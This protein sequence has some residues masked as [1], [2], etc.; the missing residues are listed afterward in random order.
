M[1]AASMLRSEWR[2]CSPASGEIRV[3]GV[4][5]DALSRHHWLKQVA[6]VEQHPSL[7][8]GSL[9]ETLRALAPEASD[10]ELVEALLQVGLG[11]WLA[12]LPRG[13]ATEL[14]D[15]GG[16]VSGGQRAR[17]ALARALLKKPRLV[18]LDEPT[19]ALDAEA[20]RAFDARL[21]ELLGNTTRL[22]ISHQGSHFSNLDAR[23]RLQDGRLIAREATA[24]P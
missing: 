10:A 11:D 12:A 19:A 22:I 6:W 5:L 3:D 16:T 1:S 24:C 8:R 7:L 2:V 23:Y 4:P 20:A 13:L 15:L 17:L 18:L 9:A 21:D 14:G